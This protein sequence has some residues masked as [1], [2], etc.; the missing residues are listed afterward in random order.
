[1]SRCD[2]VRRLRVQLQR[3]GP[4]LRAPAHRRASLHGR[5][6]GALSTG[7]SRP[8]LDAVPGAGLLPAAARAVGVAVGVAALEG[9]GGPAAVDG[10]V[11]FL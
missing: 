8:G 5:V 10:R 11:C 9:L 2:H 4:G 7:S 1:M 3:A 6:R